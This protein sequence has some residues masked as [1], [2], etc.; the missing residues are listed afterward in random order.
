MKLNNEKNVKSMYINKDTLSTRVSLHNK[1]SINKYGWHNWIFD[2]YKLNENIN[3]L[4]LGCGTGNTWIGKE[5][6]IPK[7]IKIILTDISPL[8]IEKSKEKLDKIKN[9]SFQ[10]MDIQNLPFEDKSFDIIIANHMLYHV[11]DIAKALSEIKRILKDDGSFYTTTIGKD[12]LK[13]LQDIYRSYSDKIKFQ[14]SDE[15]SFTLENGENILKKYFGIIEQKLYIDSLEVTDANDL[16]DYI[17]SY[18]EIS[19]DIYKEINE[20]IRNEIN[21]NGIFK[22]R[23]DQGMFICKI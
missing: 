8:M 7:N 15:C 20:K 21:K 14:Y 13:E 3:I 19:E 18:N 23:K 9:F 1:Y 2:Q 6:Q 22:I 5:N 10:I 4:E 16:M 12:S 17:V 11:P